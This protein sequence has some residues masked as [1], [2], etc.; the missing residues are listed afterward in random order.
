MTLHPALLQFLGSLAAILALAFAAWRLKL[1]PAP[2]L[3]DEAAAR[4]AADQAESGFEPVALAL[5]SEGR[6]ALLRDAEGRVLALRAHGAHFAG[7]ILPPGTRVRQEGDRL[8]I[9]PGERFFGR[10]TL[11]LRDAAEWARLIGRETD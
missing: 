6:G 7:R 2:R 3:A 4:H 11:T 5:D 9:D 10:V 1:G 8:E